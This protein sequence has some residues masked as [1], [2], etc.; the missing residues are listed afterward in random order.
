MAR[1]SKSGI[2]LGVDHTA[3]L[4]FTHW[5]GAHLF[6]VTVAQL[7]DVLEKSQRGREK[8][9]MTPVQNSRTLR[10]LVSVHLSTFQFGIFALTSILAVMNPIS[11]VA[12]FSTL[13]EGLSAQERQIVISTAMRVAFVVLLFF[14]FTGQFVFTILGLTLPAFKIAG[15]ILLLSLAL[16]M[17]QP[18]KVV[19]SSDELDNI[20]IVPLAFPLT[21]GAGTITTVILL[22]SEARGIVDSLVVYTSVAIAI[23][24]SYLGMQHAH[25]ILA[26]FG[27]HEIRV[28]LRLL[29]IFVLAIGVQFVMNG[30]S[31]FLLQMLSSLP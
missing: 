22:A 31:E 13:A 23:G 30:I 29:S 11:T 21:C 9:Y 15:G 2:A 8:N 14:A 10:V 20:A 18:K 27:E 1:I 6:S 16:G 4:I 26:I 12:V 19:Y 5:T 25:R 28:L 3:I 7:G 24:I 17:I